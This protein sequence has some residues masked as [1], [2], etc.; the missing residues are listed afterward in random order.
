M[1]FYL[2]EMVFSGFGVIDYDAKLRSHVVVTCL[3]LET[4]KRLVASRA[5]RGVIC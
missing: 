4:V 5:M 2:F 1:G 3:L